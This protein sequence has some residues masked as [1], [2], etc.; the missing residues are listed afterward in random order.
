MDQECIEKVVLEVL[1]VQDELVVNG[2]NAWH[3]A[4]PTKEHFGIKTEL[5]ED[6]KST[7]LNSS[8]T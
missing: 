6:R 3:L 1:R 5:N 2:H 7:R 4:E 8:H